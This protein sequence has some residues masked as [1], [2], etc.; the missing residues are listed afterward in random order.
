MSKK[1]KITIILVACF[2]VVLAIILAVSLTVGN[3]NHRFIKQMTKLNYDVTDYPYH[4]YMDYGKSYYTKMTAY[5]S[6][7]TSY[8]HV[9]MCTFHNKNDA[10]KFYDEKMAD[11]KNGYSVIQKGKRVYYGTNQGLADLGI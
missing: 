5:R 11:L 3:V 8:D 1:A 2:V 9:T 6:G 10:T 4:I 7:K